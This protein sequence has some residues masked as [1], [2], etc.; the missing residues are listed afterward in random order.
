VLAD[1]A[2]PKEPSVLWEPDT[3]SAAWVFSQLS[4]GEQQ[5]ARAWA[6]AGSASW[7][8]AADLAGVTAHDADSVRR[9]LR[10]LGR[11][12]EER[13]AAARLTRGSLTGIAGSGA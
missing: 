3:A 6:Q 7:A 5:V 9:K 4:P 1:R 13:T 12:F 11:R 2:A 8:E 10:R